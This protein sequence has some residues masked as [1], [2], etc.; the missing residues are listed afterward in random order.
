M[1][2]FTSTLA[3]PQSGPNAAPMPLGMQMLPRSKLGMPTWTRRRRTSAAALLIVGL[4]CRP[5]R[6]GKSKRADGGEGV[7]SF[8]RL[9]VLMDG[10]GQGP[11]EF[12]AAWKA[13]SSIGREVHP[14]VFAASAY[15]QR[16]DWQAFLEESDAEG[17]AVPPNTSDGLQALQRTVMAKAAMRWAKDPAISCVAL[18]PSERVG[19]P[20]SPEDANMDVDFVQLAH[21]LVSGPRARVLAVLLEGQAFRCPESVGLAEEFRSA[22]AEV[23]WVEVRWFGFRTPRMRAVLPPKP[24]AD[25]RVEPIE[26]DEERGPL[27]DITSLVGHLFR[28]GFMETPRD[29]LA[30]AVARFWHRNLQSSDLTVWPAQYPLHQLNDVLSQKTG[31]SWHT[32]CQETAFVLPVSGKGRA[33]KGNSGAMCPCRSRLWAVCLICAVLGSGWMMSTRCVFEVA[34]LFLAI[35]A[36]LLLW[37]LACRPTLCI[38]ALYLAICFAILIRALD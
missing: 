35:A 11:R 20:A 30:P 36:L 19:R 3:R 8:D 4:A 16:K 1:A 7:C 15:L 31:G 24:G 21:L 29:A 17:V 2:Y 9:V 27:P 13:L 18:M 25:G 22:H 12:R 38:S 32:L 34:V 6:A 26:E 28:H 14:F 23:F 33:T 10:D 5:Q 37:T